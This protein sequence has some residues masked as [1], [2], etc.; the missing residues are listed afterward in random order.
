MFK[1]K[2]IFYFLPSI[3]TV[4]C[5]EGYEENPADSQTCEKCPRGSYRS[6]NLSDRFKNCTKCDDSKTTLGDGSISQDDCSLS[7]KH[8]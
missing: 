7:K 3:S 1:P 2:I 4:V 5:P 6:G 8:L